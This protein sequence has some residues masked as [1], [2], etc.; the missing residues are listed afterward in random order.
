MV[1]NSNSITFTEQKREFAILHVI[2][3]PKANAQRGIKIISTPLIH[4]EIDLTVQNFAGLLF[5][6]RISNLINE[7]ITWVISPESRGIVYKRFRVNIWL[8]SSSINVNERTITQ[9]LN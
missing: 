5:A 7:L 2:K 1:V 8:N 4:Y 9:L 3:E 6:N